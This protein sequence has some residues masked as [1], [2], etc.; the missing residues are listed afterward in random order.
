MRWVVAG[1]F[2]CL[3]CGACSSSERPDPTL[4]ARPNDHEPDAG[5]GFDAGPASCSEFCG[6]TFLHEIEAPPNLYFLLDRSGSMAA[7]MEGSN[8]DKYDTARKVLGTLLQVIGHRVRYGA[9][10]F[11]ADA[12]YCGPGVEVSKL[13]LGGLPACDGEFDPVLVDFLFGIGQFSPSG[14]TPT[15]AALAAL[16]PELEELSGPTHLVLL[17]D[18]APN[19]NLEASCDADECMLNIEGQTVAGQACTPAYNCCDP[20]NTGAEGPGYCV[21]SDA[22][23]RELEQLLEHGISTFVVGMPGAEPYAGVLERL[24]R[25][26]GT[27]RSGDL[28]YYAAND[29]A[30]LQQALY[31]IGTGVAVRC[32]IDLESPP[33][34][35]DLVNVYFDGE[36]VPADPDDGWSWDGD[37]RIQVN[38][39]ACD[40]LKSGDVIDAR[41]VFGCD[42]VVR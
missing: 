24:A 28:A 42:T 8:L 37:A 21:D 12:D 13:T 4:L 26:G 31:Q 5:N 40:Q 41:A 16:R 6:E 36:I 20:A 22:T 38:G 10:V 33:E 23:A 25:A 27:A 29:Q 2:L 39:G 17:T 7:P 14:S 35:H 3:P 9:S 1:L 15:A 30:E 11:P 32:T 18:G 34:S 19:C